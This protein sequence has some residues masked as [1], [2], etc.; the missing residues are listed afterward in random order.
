MKKRKTIRENEDMPLIFPIICIVALIL[1]AA[2]VGFV[3]SNNHEAGMNELKTK[4]DSISVDFEFSN[5]CNDDRTYKINFNTHDTFTAQIDIDDE[6]SD[7]KR[8]FLG[9]EDNKVYQKIYAGSWKDV[10][11]RSDFIMP[12]TRITR[13]LEK[14]KGSASEKISFND[15]ISV[16]GIIN[17]KD[18][19]TI[20]QDLNSLTALGNNWKI[21]NYS[22]LEAKVYI[23][24]NG[25]IN[26]V[27]FYPTGKDK[28]SG[29]R[30]GDYIAKCKDITLL[31]YDHNKTI[32][33]YKEDLWNVVK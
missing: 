12:D 10:D 26:K 5:D 14:I 8:Y 9:S 30:N 11:A 28:E 18:S 2:I 33:N 23:E 15:G 13:I 3:I 31:F 16:F 1:G 19:E 24:R 29:W 7:L 4:Y 32:V 17:I 6:D 25:N 21:S 22:F 27:V 20:Y